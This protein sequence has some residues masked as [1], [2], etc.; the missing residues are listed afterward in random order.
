M[1]TKTPPIVLVA[2]L[3][4]VFGCLTARQAQAQTETTLYNFD[5]GPGGYGPV[6]SLT[7]D[8]NGNFYGTTNSGGFSGNGV[9]YE[10]SP[11]GAGG[12]NETVLYN[13]CPPSPPCTDGG[14]P[15]VGSLIF[16]GAGNLY[17][18]AGGGAYGYGVVFELSPAGST[19]TY[20][21]LYNFNPANGADGAGPSSGLTMDGKGNLYGTTAG[22]PNGDGTVYELSAS[23]GGWTEQVIYDEEGPGPD[24]GLAIDAVGNL[25]GVSGGLGGG[26]GVG[27]VFELS[28][29]GSGGWN[30]SVIYSFG[31]SDGEYPEGTPFLDGAGNVYGT[32]Q[33]GGKGYGTVWKLS[34]GKKKWEEKV[35]HSFTG[36]KDGNQPFTGVVLDASGN[37]YGTTS[38][39]GE[40]LDGNVFEL[41]VSGTTYKEKVLWSFGDE[42]KQ[43]SSAGPW[44]LI[45]DGGELY[46]TTEFDGL[47]DGGV[48]FEVNPSAAAT[49]TTLTSS[50]N[51]STS[52]E[53][54]TFTATVSSSAGAPPDGETVNF[55]EGSTLLGTGTLSGGSANFM[56]SSLPVGT[57]KIDAVYGGDLNFGPSTSKAVKQ[58]VKK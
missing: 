32:T 39:G 37:I 30:N 2:A 13:F 16:D 19:W 14:P 6:S 21:V 20:S 55:M 9:V 57:S 3:T 29:N 56:T 43:E 22:G 12:Y 36:T 15:N 47:Y 46:G 23:G 54:V 49:T 40:Y 34:P 4:V 8:G 53:T 10:L 5:V 25:Y 27:S 50:P 11:A 58:V 33:Y 28:P 45:L 18:T 38:Y 31:G 42:S 48:A 35:L 51:P 26:Q 1:Q 7:P 17:G 24:A 41:A 52:G 44:G